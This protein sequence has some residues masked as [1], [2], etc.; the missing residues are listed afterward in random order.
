MEV[1]E[2]PIVNGSVGEIGASHGK[3]R[4]PRHREVSRS[5]PRLRGVGGATHPSLRTPGRPPRGFSL[6]RDSGLS[7]AQPHE[8]VVP[9]FLY[10]YVAKL[11]YSM[12]PPGSSTLFT[13]RGISSQRLMVRKYGRGMSPAPHWHA[14]Y[15]EGSAKSSLGRD[16][17][18]VL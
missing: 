2:H 5:A 11:V 15:R 1:H 10:A 8:L 16:R 14:R 17:R 6:R 4:F 3:Q 12:M 18:S 13:S 7:T 9:Y